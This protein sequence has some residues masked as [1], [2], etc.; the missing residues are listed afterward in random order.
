[1]QFKVKGIFELPTPLF[2]ARAVNPGDD[3]KFSASI[4]I[5]KMTHKLLKFRKLLSKKKAN[6][7]PNGFPANR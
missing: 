3:P 7:F 5:K 2:T 4:L 1:M 6:G